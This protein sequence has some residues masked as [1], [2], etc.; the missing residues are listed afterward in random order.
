MQAAPAGGNAR[1]LASFSAVYRR[2]G[3]LPQN[4]TN[5]PHIC[6]GTGPTR[7]R[8]DRETRCAALAAEGGARAFFRGNGANVVKIAP[9]TGATTSFRH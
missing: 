4:Q 5:A 9:E 2:D 1:L 6:A 8:R 7:L 3:F